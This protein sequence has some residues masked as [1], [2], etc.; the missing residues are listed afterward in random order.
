MQVIFS[1]KIADE[2]R[3][4]YTILELETFTV[5]DQILETFCVVSGEKMNLADLPHLADHIKMH[6]EFVE[7]LKQKNYK[8][9]ASAIEQLMGKFGG[10]L[11]SFYEIVLE[12]CKKEVT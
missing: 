7:Q 3:D 9:C 6:E 10:E 5:Q 1:R 2:L 11:D 4:R 12:R 8:F